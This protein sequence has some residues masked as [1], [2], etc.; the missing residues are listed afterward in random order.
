MRLESHQFWRVAYKTP[1][2]RDPGKCWCTLDAKRRK[3]LPSAPSPLRVKSTRCIL[4]PA[5][6]AVRLHQVLLTARSSASAPV[7]LASAAYSSPE[8]A[9]SAAT[10][11]VERWGVVA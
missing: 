10:P 3:P 8:L 5:L 11:V 4:V 9:T 2:Q 7:I 1:S 6:A